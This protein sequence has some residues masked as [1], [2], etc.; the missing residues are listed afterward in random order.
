MK[1]FSWITFAEPVIRF[2]IYFDRELWEGDIIA[3]EGNALD[4]LLQFFV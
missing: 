3:R 1:E 4:T 2:Q